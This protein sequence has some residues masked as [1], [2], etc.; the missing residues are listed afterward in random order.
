MRLVFD[1]HAD[2]MVPA[3]VYLY[4]TGLD[5]GESIA[6]VR[7]GNGLVEFPAR[8]DARVQDYLRPRQ[9]ASLVVD[10]STLQHGPHWRLLVA[11]RLHLGRLLRWHR[12]LWTRLPFK[13]VQ[14]SQNNSEAENA[15]C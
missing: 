4:S 13:R 7:A 15:A 11:R 3:V 8:G 2:V 5:G 6:A 1:A 9:R 10:N 14:R 12:L